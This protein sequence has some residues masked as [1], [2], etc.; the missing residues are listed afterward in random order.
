MGKKFMGIVLLLVGAVGA[1]VVYS[2]RPPAGFGEA[3]MMLGQG[4]DFVIADPYY[5]IFMLFFV[6]LGVWGFV[7]LIRAGQK[8]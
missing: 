2:F 3:L 7:K 6:L 1:I 5:G 4:R 8:T